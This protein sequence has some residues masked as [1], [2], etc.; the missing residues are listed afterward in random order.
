V[1]ELGADWLRRHPPGYTGFASLDAARA[2]SRV[3]FL[4]ASDTLSEP[5]PFDLHALREAM[6]A[7]DRR[8]LECFR[9]RIELSE[10]VVSAKVRSAVPIRDR[11]REEQV[12]QRVRQMA[13]E[14]H[15]DPHQMERLFRL[16]IELSVSHQQSHLANLAEIPLR[17]AYQGVE[18]SFSHLTAQRRYGGRPSGVVLSGY[19]TFHE[20]A[21]SVRGGTNDVALLPIENSTAGSINETYD[22]LAEG[23]LQITAEV[24]SEI[25]HCLLA[26]PGTRL[27]DIRFVRSHPQALAQCEVYLRSLLG[28]RVETDFDTAGAARRVRESNDPK[29]AAIASESAAQV[30][31]LEILAR[32]IQNQRSNYTRF[33]EVAIEAATCPPDVPCKTSL[34]LATAHTPGSLGE[35]LR[36]FSQRGVN[37][38]KLESRPIP[39]EPWSYRFYLDIE[40]NAAS[41]PMAAALEAILPFV[42]ELRVLGTYP[43]AEQP[44]AAVA[45]AASRERAEA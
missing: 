10:H 16:V 37:M 21:V 11:L 5:G 6:E 31:G 9:E 40:G 18:G 12:F 28:V 19:E 42:R 38:T 2:R 35:V 41:A 14:L 36:H 1:G 20:A 24:I 22:Q 45:A 23:G 26:L 32:D 34:L 8:L 44:G 29:V 17:V 27:E 30:F 4:R 13:A 3:H 15:L 33:V 7:I 39:G 25:A 43:R